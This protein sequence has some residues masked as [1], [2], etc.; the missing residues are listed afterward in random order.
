MQPGRR[1]V[2]RCC[3]LSP[4]AALCQGCS[5]SATKGSRLRAQGVETASSHT[6]K[7]ERCQPS[8]P[9]PSLAWA[10][11]IITRKRVGWWEGTGPALPW[12]LALSISFIVPSG[13]I[14][15]HTVH[16]HLT[17]QAPFFFIPLSRRKVALATDIATCMARVEGPPFAPLLPFDISRA[18]TVFPQCL[19]SI[20]KLS[21][22]CASTSK[23]FLFILQC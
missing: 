9:A 21:P 20:L 15:T 7:W 8:A 5:S 16:L 14:H 2:C 4:P 3:P 13:C 12:V 6:G 11:P 1:G 22:I 23:M 19:I 17:S 18:I 10:Q